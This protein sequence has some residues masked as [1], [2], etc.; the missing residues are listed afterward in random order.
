MKKSQKVLYTIAILFLWMV[1][2]SSLRHCGMNRESIGI[3]AIVLFI[4]ALLVLI[5]IWKNKEVSNNQNQ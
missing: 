2:G 4:G 1:L 5:Y 3:A